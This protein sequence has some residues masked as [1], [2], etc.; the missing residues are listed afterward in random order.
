[1]APMFLD[2]L[3]PTLS[4]GAQIEE[5]LGVGSDVAPEKGSAPEDGCLSILFK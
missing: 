5:P 2:S 4:L 1:M 3:A